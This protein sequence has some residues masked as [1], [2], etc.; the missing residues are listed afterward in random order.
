MKNDTKVQQINVEWRIVSPT[1]NNLS[2]TIFLDHIWV[3]IF[4]LIII[5]VIFKIIYQ[6]ELSFLLPTIYV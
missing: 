6:C 4:N 1:S 3:Y 5:Y 2:Y